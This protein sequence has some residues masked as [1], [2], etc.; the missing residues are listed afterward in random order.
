M[1]YSVLDQQ[2]LSKQDSTD[3]LKEVE[4]EL[5]ENGSAI[6]ATMKKIFSLLKSDD[7]K[8]IVGKVELH[9]TEL[10]KLQSKS[11]EL[12]NRFTVTANKVAGQLEVLSL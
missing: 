4:K 5:M 6:N 11:D 10:K 8:N 1:C 3:P 2:H 9:C 12:I 7:K